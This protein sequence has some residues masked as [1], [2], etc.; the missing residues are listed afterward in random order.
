MQHPRPQALGRRSRRPARAP[1]RQI[2]RRWPAAARRARSSRTTP[3]PTD[4]RRGGRDHDRERRRLGA[5]GAEG[6]LDARDIMVGHP[7]AHKG[8]G[9]ADAAA[10][11][12][13]R[14]PGSSGPIQASNTGSPNSR[15][16]RSRTAAHAAR[17]IRPHRFARHLSHISYPLLFSTREPRVRRAFKLVSRIPALIVHCYLV[18]C[19]RPFMIASRE[20]PRPSSH[21]VWPRWPFAIEV[22]FEAARDV[23]GLGETRAASSP[24][25]RRASARPSGRGTAPACR[26]PAPAA[27]ALPRP[28]RQNRDWAAWW[29]S[30]AIRRNAPGGPRPERS[31]RPTKFHSATVRTSTSWAL[32]SL[33]Q[34]RPRPR[35]APR[36]P[37]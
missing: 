12:S 8:L 5:L 9:R 22:A 36:S 21:C 32:G 16:M 29:E 11:P 1:R 27:A 2:G 13:R 19:I 23:E 31:G 20:G 28:R 24:W 35:Q 34:Q 37:A 18:A 15:R 14:I 6:A 33:C 30:S 7:V 25:P 26:G 10:R 17:P 4:R 3:P